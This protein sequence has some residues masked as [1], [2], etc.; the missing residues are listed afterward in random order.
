MTYDVSDGTTTTQ[1][2]ATITVTGVNDAPVAADDAA[3]VFVGTEFTGNAISGSMTGADFDLDAN[4]MLTVS[5]LGDSPIADTDGASATAISDYGTLVVGRDGS[6]NYNADQSGASQL[7]YGDAA[8]TDNFTYTLSDGNEGSDT[9]TI[10][11]SV[12]APNPTNTLP[13]AADNTL[14]I[15]EDA[16]VTFVPEHFNFNDA[17]DDRLR[18]ITIVSVP[19]AG[20]LMNGRNPINAG[21]TLS[22]GEIENLSYSP[23]SN[24]NGTDYASLTFRVNDG[25]ADSAAI[26]NMTFDI[27]ARNDLPTAAHNRVT[28]DEDTSKSFSV[29]EFGFADVDADNSLSS[30]K[31]TSL[32]AVG[33]LTLGNTALEDGD[34][35]AEPD[36]DNVK[37]TP[38]TNASGDAY[39]SFTF[40]VNDGTVDSASSYKMTVDVAPTNDLSTAADNT[41]T[42]AEDGTH[43]F[44]SSEFNFADI[45][46][47]SLDHITIVTVPAAGTLALNG[48][49]VGADDDIAAADITN[50][51]FVPIANASG[52]EYASFTF[53]VNDGTADS[54]SSYTMTV[55]VTPTNDLPTAADKTVTVA[56]DSSHTFASNEFN[57][58]DT[59]EDSL[60]HITIATLPAAGTLTLNG[61]AVDAED[62]IAAADITN[63]VF[64]P[65]TNAS[66][67]PYAS[68][69]FTVNDG[70]DDSQT[71]N[72]MTVNVTQ[73]NDAPTATPLS[74][75]FSKTDA[76][77]TFDLLQ[78]VT[79]LEGNELSLTSAPGVTFIDKMGNQEALPAGAAV[80]NG[81]IVEI[82][83]ATFSSLGIGEDVSIVIDYVISDGDETVNNSAIITISGGNTQPQIIDETD[84][85]REGTA[86]VRTNED[87]SLTFAAQ[88]F[89]FS[90]TDANDTLSHVAILTLPENG[91]LRLDGDLVETG[92]VIPEDQI[93]TLTFTPEENGNGEN[94]ANFRYLVSDGKEN[95]AAGTMS[96]HVDAVNDLPT[97]ENGRLQLNGDDEIAL[98][99]RNFAFA[100]IEGDSLNHVTIVS[101]PTEGTLYLNNQPVQDGDTIAESQ[102]NL[103]TYKPGDNASG[104]N[105]DAFTF[106]VN[107]GEEDSAS[108]STIAIGVNAA[109]AASDSLLETNE[110]ELT[111]AELLAT[112][113]DDAILQYEITKQPDHGTLRLIN[114]GPDYIYT[115]DA[116]YYG[117]DSFKFV[118][119]DTVL[120]SEEAVVSFTVRPVNNAP[121]ERRSL[122]AQAI[123]LEGKVKPIKLADFFGDVDAFDPSKKGFETNVKNLLEIGKF[124]KTAKLDPIPLDGM[125]TFTV[126]S[127]L[128]L[129]LT[130][131]GQSISGRPTEA[132]VYDI[133]MQATD[134]LELKVQSSFQLFVGMPVGISPIEAPQQEAKREDTKT[135]ETISN[136]N[137][138]DLPGVLKVNPKSD[139]IVPMRDAIAKDYPAAALGNSASL[140]E[141]A[142]TRTTF[143]SEQD[144]SGNLRV[145]DLE[146]NG[147]EIA[148]RLADGAV[149]QAETFKGKMA[150]GSKLPDWIQVDLSTGQTKALPPQ[151][152]MPVEMV[153]IANDGAGNERAI[154]LILNPEAL[155]EEAKDAP[156]SAR[157]TDQERRESRQSERQE[158]RETR[159]AERQER[160]EARQAERQVPLEAREENTLERKETRAVRDA[161]RNN[162]E[163]S[164]LTD[165]SV[166]F[167]EG[168]TA[169]G[170]GSMELMRMVSASE[171]MTIEITDTS[172]IQTTRYEVRQQDGAPA[173][174]WVQIDAATGALII[175]APKNTST[176]KL[177]LVAFDGTQQRS[178]DLDINL[179]KMRGDF[180]VDEVTTESEDT[181]TDEPAAASETTVGQ[182]LP[183]DKQID[184][185]LTDTDYGQDLQATIQERS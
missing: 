12:T 136:L 143:S 86:S 16:S 20:T 56:E 24:A 112:D 155:F 100:D 46:S 82:S 125:L 172:R 106:S 36:I 174:D 73:I 78:G 178:V 153:V 83:P 145:A 9:A 42:I 2:T 33:T 88:Q 89:N 22:V 48:V 156:L 133:I 144:I 87:T 183:L 107:D 44:A 154:N 47:D 148:V 177:T 40:T 123:M 135:E 96:L 141:D 166:R 129:G 68:F 92:D 58:A 173:P 25:T 117:S 17:D 53:T 114:G 84:D 28:I 168:L 185:A 118:A 147:Q 127:P 124:P 15:S 65:V 126:E 11:F 67:D 121:I 170:E 31:I 62:S 139:G 122:P 41:I 54:A 102:L 176:I 80:I 95:S 110:G 81:N 115:P 132:G 59:D 91:D 19:Q 14:L 109:P 169:V 131:N 152:A 138:H 55:D 38:V 101:A 182:F 167:V 113:Q 75:A 63:L 99:G 161:S 103:L 142:L 98:S 10:S 66:G 71:V 34:V 140:A 165:G 116:F 52:D 61:V 43:R 164:V 171:S 134:G 111:R 128:P 1:N 8:I 29:A 57:F 5:A 180:L 70:T 90:D 151:G 32:P 130:F 45:D 3:N 162:P 26:Y 23:A 158:R 35:I 50:L 104:V 21:D 77:D 27:T 79:D 60:D 76:D 97:T 105:Y 93:R 159:Q 146:I 64:T 108:A 184:A 163:F 30:I 7:S 39:A 150:D 37:F 157:E 13:T 175:E 4:T 149:D 181:Q 49:A 94:Y 179:D 72:T 51:V 119:S 18:Q 120:T 6:V 74:I 69:T 85:N 160:R 137:D